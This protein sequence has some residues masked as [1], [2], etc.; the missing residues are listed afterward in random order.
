MHFMIAFQASSSYFKHSKQFW[1]F[2]TEWGLWKEKLAGLNKYLSQR[3]FMW[4]TELNFY[5]KWASMLKTNWKRAYQNLPKWLKIVWKINKIAKIW[6]MLFRV[7]WKISRQVYKMVPTKLSVYES[8]FPVVFEWF[9]NIYI[10][11]GIKI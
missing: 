10:D 5:T 1:H 7:M 8:T 11:R 4:Q 2:E 9:L 6:T 3:K